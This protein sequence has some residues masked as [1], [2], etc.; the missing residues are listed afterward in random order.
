VTDLDLAP[1]AL[2]ERCPCDGCRHAARCK[3]QLLSCEAFTMYV[4]S[5]SEKRWRLAPRAP[6]SAR[7]QA[8]LEGKP[9]RPGRRKRVELP[10]AA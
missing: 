3:A 6:T 4:H 10:E 5:E 1:A 8:L 2:T 7:Y 9:G